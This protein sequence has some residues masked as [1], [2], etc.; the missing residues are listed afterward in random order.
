M[1]NCEIECHLFN[2]QKFP[3]NFKLIYRRDENGGRAW[4]GL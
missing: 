2:A 3:L 4:D 1:S